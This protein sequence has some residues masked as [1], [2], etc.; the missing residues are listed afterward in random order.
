[1]Q[2][3]LVVQLL[4]HLAPLARYWAPGAAQAALPTCL[5]ELLLDTPGLLATDEAKAGFKGLLRLLLAPPSA[6][7]AACQTV[8]DC[9]RLLT[10]QTAACQTAS[11]C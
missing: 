9:V 3:G 2:A 6:T 1:M 4:S 11:D 7:G 10:R 8:S 5:A